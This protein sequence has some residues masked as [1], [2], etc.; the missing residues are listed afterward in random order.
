MANATP[1]L[2]TLSEQCLRLTFFSV[3]AIMLSGLLPHSPAVSFPFNKWNHS[4]K[5][6]K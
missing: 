5:T 1:K 4:L 3:K 6:L 2:V